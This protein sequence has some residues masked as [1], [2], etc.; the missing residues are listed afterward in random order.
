MGQQNTKP[1]SKMDRLEQLN[2]DKNWEDEQVIEFTELAK[3]Y[4]LL[5]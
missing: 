5:P 1:L 2:K 3:G 4:L